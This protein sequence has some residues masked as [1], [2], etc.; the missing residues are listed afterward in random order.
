MQLGAI[1]L[2]VDLER[3]DACDEWMVRLGDLDAVRAYRGMRDELAAEQLRH[4]GE[5]AG[6]SEGCSGAEGRRR[7]E[8][9]V[10]RVQCDPPATAFDERLEPALLQ[11][12]RPNVACV[13]D[14]QIGGI[15]RASWLRASEVFEHAHLHAVEMAELGQQLQPRVIEVVVP[16]SADD[17]G[18]DPS[19]W[20]HS[21]SPH[22]QSCTRLANPPS[23]TRLAPV[24]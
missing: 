11:G 3:F 7:L 15:E 13:R 9:R 4:H 17:D 20:L 19:T 12:A 16:A 6:R 23:T 18:I 14:E 24:M 1:E 21:V 22:D 5:R 8:R 10:G 2:V